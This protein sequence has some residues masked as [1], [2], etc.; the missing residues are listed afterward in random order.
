[1]R[2]MTKTIAA[3]LLILVACAPAF[4]QS[5]QIPAGTL[6]GNA[7]A[8]TAVAKAV[9]ASA[10]LDR[11]IGSTQGNVL[12]RGNTG[13]VGSPTPVLGIPGTTAGKVT[14]SALTTGAIT[15]QTAS[16]TATWTLT[17]PTSPGSNG[18]VLS[19]DGN[20]NTSWVVQSGGGGGG[21]VNG[22]VSSTVGFAPLWDN[23]AGTLIGV[24]LPVATTGTNT[25]VETNSSGFLAAGVMP[26]LTG[27]I[28]SSAGG[29]AT[30]YNNVVPVTKGGAGAINGAL[31]GNG[32]GT[33]SQ[34][35]ASDLSNGV[36]GS[37][38]VVLAAGSPTFTGTPIAPTAAG[39]TNTT[40]IATTAFVQAAVA[41]GGAS[42]PVV[43]TFHSPGD[44]TPGTTT[45]LTLSSAPT[46]AALLRLAFDGLDQAHDTWT[47]VGAAL[48]F[49]AAIPTNTQTVAAQWY[50]PAIAAGV[51]SL[52]GMTGAITC[53]TGL[54]C[55]ASTISVTSGALPALTNGN[56]WIGNVSDVATANTI[57]GA[58]T[59]SNAGVLT[60]ST[61][62]T[63]VGSFGSA[64]VVPSFTVNAKGLIT[65]ASSA[66]VVAPAS[67][68]SGTTLNGSVVNSSLTSVGTLT[69][70]ATG[71]GFTLNF[72]TSTISGTLTVPK[73]GTGATTFT[74]NRPLIGNGA[75]VIAQGTVTSTNSSTL[76][77]TASGS[78]ASGN[79]LKS[80]PNQNIVDA[81]AACATSPKSVTNFGALC[82]GSTDDTTAFNNAMTGGGIVTIPAGTCIITGV[83]AFA[84]NTP[85]WLQGSG[86]GISIIKQT[87]TTA[88]AIN[89]QNTSFTANMGGISNLSI[90]STTS[91]G[92]ALDIAKIGTSDPVFGGGWILNNLF[93][94]GF[95]SGI[96]YKD[97]WFTNN[98]NLYLTDQTDNQIWMDFGT[99]HTTGGHAFSNIQLINS[100]ATFTGV[101]SAGNV[102]TV[103]GITGTI[104]VGDSITFSGVNA[105][106]PPPTVS[107]F[108]TGGTTGTG[109]NGTYS[110][111]GAPGAQSSQAMRSRRSSRSIRI[112]DSGGTVWSNIGQ[113]AALYGVQ[114]DPPTGNTVI[115][116]WFSNAVFD[117]NAKDGIR[118]DGVNGG[119]VHGLYCSNCW[120]SYNA[121]VGA[122]L[123]GSAGSPFYDIWFVGSTFAQNQY[124]GVYVNTNTNWV[125]VQDSSVRDNSCTCNGATTNVWPGIEVIGGVQHFTATGNVL[126]NV[127]ASDQSYGLQLDTSGT[128]YVIVQGNDTSTS[129][130]KSGGLG[131][132][133]NSGAANKSISGNL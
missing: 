26:A 13:W 48:T 14:L 123:S 25:I 35:A 116:Q 3:A 8:A 111:A 100:Q 82:D 90:I 59:M 20:G 36:T 51:N 18:Y 124:Q 63:N 23:T 117:T 22:P 101:I 88:N 52:G 11:S 40:Q 76:F 62:N 68:L 89:V 9:T 33:V 45:T 75:G 83:V 130:T 42:T 1:M 38:A 5:G 94:S 37:G 4:G 53:G 120:S 85:T 71:S 107:T 86:P 129:S 64:S 118:L 119:A 78:W 12:F 57:S 47:L 92:I 132:L 19:T 96:R 34:A 131:I 110:L 55:A 122:I 44:F 112:R 30:S 84:I 56:I 102:L 49:N 6:W 32:S 74:A 69:G 46:S 95:G 66:T 121:G 31:K 126:G 80:D 58:A 99:V 67:T 77:A 16:T 128:N 93:I 65:A 97:S 73:G 21:S 27:D 108:G 113:E 70:G 106:G 125:R 109:G 115:Y 81:G 28:T 29:V 79:C 39:G 41:G 61:V 60:L 114:I 17:L 43:Q 72:T 127:T 7:T 103:S 98:S 24:G 104:K 87:S 50:A 105:S 10:I 91:T 2:Q 15:L 133:D 54:L